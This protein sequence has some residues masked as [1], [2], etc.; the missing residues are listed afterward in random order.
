MIDFIHQNRASFCMN[1]ISTACCF[2]QILCRK[3]EG[4]GIIVNGPRCYVVK[5]GMGAEIKCRR[6]TFPSK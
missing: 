2:T 1:Y 3:V 5:L 6:S 4:W